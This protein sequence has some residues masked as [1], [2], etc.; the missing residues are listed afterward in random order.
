MSQTQT[1]IKFFERDRDEYG[2]LSNFAPSP[3]TDL[4]GVVWPTAE[5]A[6]QAEKCEAEEDRIRIYKAGTP[7]LAKRLGRKVQLPSDWEDVKVEVML[8]IVYAKFKQNPELAEKLV[9]TGYATLIE[10]SPHDSFW[11]AGPNGTGRN[12]LGKILMEV[13]G[14]I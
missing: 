6:F 5:H 10:D 1:E 14:I 8:R 11:G 7:L 2:W 13:R 3:I 4:Y 12:E 9:A